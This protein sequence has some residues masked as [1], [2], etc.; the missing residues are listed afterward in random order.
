MSGDLSSLAATC[1]TLKGMD[2]QSQSVV[3]LL[4]IDKLVRINT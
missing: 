1:S 4:T 2:K 3:D